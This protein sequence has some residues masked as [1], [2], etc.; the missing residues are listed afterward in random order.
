MVKIFEIT[1]AELD[2]VEKFADALWGKLGID[3]DFTRHFLDRVNDERNGKPI[4]A[5]ELIRLFKKEYAEHGRN[6]SKLSNTEA[7]MKDLL[8]NINLPFVYLDNNQDKDRLVAKTVMRK[9]DF[10]TSDPEFIVDDTEEDVLRH[11]EN[12]KNIAQ[13]LKQAGYKKIGS[14][15]DS[16]VWTKDG[17]NVIKIV[18]PELSTDLKGAAGLM[19]DFY[20]FCQIHKNSPFLPKFIKFVNKELEQF[21]EN[22]V[23]Y[24][25]IGMEKLQKLNQQSYETAFYWLLTDLVTRLSSWEQILNTLD[26]DKFWHN[27]LST[28]HA[29]VNTDNVE[30]KAYVFW[31]KLQEDYKLISKIQAFFEIMRACYEFGRSKG[32]AWDLH[33]ENIMRRGRTPVIVD[34]WTT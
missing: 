26:S 12:R 25:L 6:I 24:V 31:Q 4:N 8:T 34:P 23:D 30:E 14:G 7:V 17:Q 18:M 13:T 19:N 20:N 32:Y 21:S 22:G 16:T 27:F 9:S 3:I 29:S 11:A 28:I 33:T 15:I 5:A 10:K 2:A 1:A